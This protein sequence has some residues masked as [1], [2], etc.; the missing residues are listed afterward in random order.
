MAATSINKLA[1]I[2]E[3]PTFP[4]I[5]SERT[6]TTIHAIHELLNSNMESVNTNL[7]CGTLGHLC[8]NLSCTVYA[9]LSAT[10]FVP[11]P[12]TGATPVIPAG[13]TGPEAAFIRYAHEGATLTFNTFRNVDRALRQ[14]LLGAVKDNFV[15]V[16]HRLHQGYSG[17][18]TLDLLTQLSKTYAIISNA[19]YLAN[20]KCFRKAYAPIKT[21][22]VVWRQIDDEVAYT[23]AGSM[24]YS[25]K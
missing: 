19:K 7:G 12:N 6:Y 5:E 13:T 18:S 4:P 2:L 3:N 25:T 10:C 8:L 20:Y 11:S 23:N 15:Q 1:E 22:E 24:P 9:T 21:I 17:S 16:K 14:Q